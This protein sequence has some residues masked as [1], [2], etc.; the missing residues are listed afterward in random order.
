MFD[1]TRSERFR[2]VSAVLVGTVHVTALSDSTL[3][4][5]HNPWAT[6][7]FAVDAL[8]LPQVT[9][10]HEAA[11]PRFVRTSGTP[12]SRVLGLPDEWPQEVAES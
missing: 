8:P 1:P 2:R 6:R 10:I 12:L 5:Y 3:T 11:G 9:L 7:P 4:V